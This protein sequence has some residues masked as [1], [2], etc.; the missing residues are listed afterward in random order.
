MS[1]KGDSAV[2]C[3][4]FGVKIM[5]WGQHFFIMCC[6]DCLK[7]AREEVIVRTY[8]VGEK[9]LLNVDSPKGTTLLLIF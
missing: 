9:S 4:V 1:R 2:W 3:T 7:Q 6:Y 8:F 5:L